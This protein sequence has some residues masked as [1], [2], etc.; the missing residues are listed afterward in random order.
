[1]L[2]MSQ[3]L[4]ILHTNMSNQYFQGQ[5]YFQRTLITLI[6]HSYFGYFLFINHDY[7]FLLYLHY[8]NLNFYQYY[9]HY[10]LLN[11]HQTSWSYHFFHF[12]NPHYYQFLQNF[13]L[14]QI[15]Y[16]HHHWKTEIVLFVHQNLHQYQYLDR[17]YQN[18]QYRLF[19]SHYQHH[20][21]NHYLFNQSY[22]I[23][24][25]HLLFHRYFLYLSPHLIHFL[26]LHFLV[27]SEF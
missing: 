3:L 5:F 21:R 27:S 19:M 16:F 15:S 26:S 13:N 23:F 25:R 17:C 14:Q 24:L 18:F 9:Y 22:C 20:H 1:M 12:P 7:Y 11:H 8:L 2:Q 4:Q 10:L 6:K